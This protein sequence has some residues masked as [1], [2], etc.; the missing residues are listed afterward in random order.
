MNV[1]LARTEEIEE[2]HAHVF[3]GLAN[4]Q[5]EK[6]FLNALGGGKPLDHAA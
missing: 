6:V 5:Q 1:L 2:V 3:A 4:A